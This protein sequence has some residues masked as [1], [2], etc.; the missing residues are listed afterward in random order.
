MKNEKQQF[1]AILNSMK[2]SQR[3]KPRP[4]LLAQIQN[5][6][7]Q[8]VVKVLTISQIR[9]IAAVGLLL[10]TL[11][12]YVFSSLYSNNALNEKELVLQDSEESL[13]SNFQIYE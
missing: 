11:N 9:R 7:Q 1:D 6:I 4:D 12:V 2:G 5:K 3:A 13:I 8:P 10:M